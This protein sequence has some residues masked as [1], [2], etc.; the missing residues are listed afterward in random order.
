MAREFT[1]GKNAK[2]KKMKARNGNELQIID[3]SRNIRTVHYLKR[4]FILF[5]D[6]I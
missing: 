6:I 1:T 4:V 3:K 5:R 2:G